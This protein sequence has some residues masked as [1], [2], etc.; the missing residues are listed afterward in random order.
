MSIPQI[1]YAPGIPADRSVIPH[2]WDCANAADPTC[3]ASAYSGLQEF[4]DVG[5]G[6]APGVDKYWGVVILGHLIWGAIEVA[7]FKNIRTKGE[8]SNILGPANSWIDQVS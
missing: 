4:P 5:Y 2:I 6:L 8:V 7:R 1:D 3:P